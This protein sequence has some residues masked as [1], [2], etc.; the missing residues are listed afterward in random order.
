M[1]EL[2]KKDGGKWVP[3]AIDSYRTY[4]RKYMKNTHTDINLILIINSAGSI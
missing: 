4:L 1:I 3:M 2:I